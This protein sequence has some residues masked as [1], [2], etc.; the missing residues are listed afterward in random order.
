[1]KRNHTKF[2]Q[3]RLIQLC[4]TPDRYQQSGNATGAFCCHC[5]KTSQG[6][7]QHSS[8]P[9]HTPR[10]VAL[11][12]V[13][14]SHVLHHGQVT[15]RQQRYMHKETVLVDMQLSDNKA[16]SGTG[17]EE[18]NPIGKAVTICL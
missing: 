13:H 7:C 3:R 4:I 18:Q 5:C 8:A 9:S 14:H 1:M 10:Y 15:N 17:L 12:D 2:V 6:H 16:V 11:K